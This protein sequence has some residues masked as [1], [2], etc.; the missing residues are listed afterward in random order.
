MS[1][2]TLFLIHF[3]ELWPLNSTA[4]MTCSWGS[5][6]VSALAMKTSLLQSGQVSRDSNRLV[7]T[8]FTGTNKVR[9]RKKPEICIRK[10]EEEKKRIELD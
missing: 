1:L 10:Q 7:K 9:I 2:E 6:L 3:I 4:L 8:D 5:E